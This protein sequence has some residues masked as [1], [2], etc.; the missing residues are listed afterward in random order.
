MPKRY[1]FRSAVELAF[2][3][4]LLLINTITSGAL[5]FVGD[6]VQQE[7]EFQ[8]K[9]LPKRYNWRRLSKTSHCCVMVF[10]TYFFPAIMTI[11]GIG[12]GPLHHYFY[13]GID[14]IWPVRDITSVVKKILSD[15]FV[16]APMCIAY[17]FYFAGVCEFRPIS[18]STEE[19][20]KKF[21][22]VYTVNFL[23]YSS[24]ITISNMNL[25]SFTQR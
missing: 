4:H 18:D 16:M 24:Q 23:H 25:E 11:V 8:R 1:A 10:F 20:K 7:I 13:L 6:I 14:K 3:K 12:Y 17:F 21:I 5:M 15:Q 2:S 9:M 19:L 22:E